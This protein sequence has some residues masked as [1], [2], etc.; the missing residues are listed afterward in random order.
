MKIKM[1]MRGVTCDG[2]RGGGQGLL[3]W[4]VA[5]GGGWAGGMLGARIKPQWERQSLGYMN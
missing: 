3:S 5:A 1:G 2:L 4:T